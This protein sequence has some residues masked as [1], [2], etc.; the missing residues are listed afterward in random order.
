[1]EKHGVDTI[2]VAET[3]ELKVLSDALS[4][5]EDTIQKSPKNRLL[6]DI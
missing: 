5:F 3:E 2:P 4:A 6:K 1:M